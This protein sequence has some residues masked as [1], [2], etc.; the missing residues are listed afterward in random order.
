MRCQALHSN[1]MHGE[2]ERELSSSSD[3]QPNEC[4]LELN[5]WSWTAVVDALRCMWE[6]GH[7]DCASAH[8]VGRRLVV[9]PP[10][11]TH[12]HTGLLSSES[13]DGVCA[14]EV[15]EPPAAQPSLTERRHAETQSAR[16]LASDA[17][18]TREIE[19]EP[20]CDLG[21]PS[22][23]SVPMDDGGV[24]DAC[25]R[26]RGGTGVSECVSAASA[27]ASTAD[28]AVATAGA[29]YEEQRRVNI[30]NNKRMLEQLGVHG[31]LI[32]QQSHSMADCRLACAH[33][34]PAHS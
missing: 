4:S 23:L 12:S 25:N 29:C 21:E 9:H 11:L 20:R 1:G 19:V 17:E 30:A 6:R 32:A 10:P 24:V 2:N 31:C 22:S 26:H 14:I 34:G 18:M 27:P 8:L 16:D 33:C 15:A 13:S 28:E 5:Q 3:P 7:A